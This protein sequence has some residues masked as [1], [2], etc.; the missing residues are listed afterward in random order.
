MFYYIVNKQI[1]NIYDGQPLRITGRVSVYNNE[2]KTDMLTEIPFTEIG[3][4]LSVAD[5]PTTSKEEFESFIEQKALEGIDQPEI[6]NKLTEV[7]TLHDLGL[8]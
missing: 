8:L 7:K 3:V 5:C 4:N 1:T 6:Q 2:S